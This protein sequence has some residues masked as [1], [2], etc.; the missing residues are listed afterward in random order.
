MGVP[1]RPRPCGFH[2]ALQLTHWLYPLLG[3]TVTTTTPFSGSPALGIPRRRPFLYLCLLL[4]P[5][6]LG[7]RL[8]RMPNNAVEDDHLLDEPHTIQLG[9]F[10]VRGSR[11]HVLS[12]LSRRPVPGLL[13]NE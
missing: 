10:G 5:V 13:M 7:S 3:P 4:R 9:V 2:S 1:L 8:D 11:T 12:T 6:S